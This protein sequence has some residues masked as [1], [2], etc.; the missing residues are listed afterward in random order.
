MGISLVE[1]ELVLFVDHVSIL[2]SSAL[3]PSELNVSSQIP[4]RPWPLKPTGGFVNCEME[5]RCEL[6]F[7][8]GSGLC[9]LASVDLEA[10]DSGDCI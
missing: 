2:M 9:G 3:S 8:F 1:P 6:G 5:G 4:A 7:R 10:W